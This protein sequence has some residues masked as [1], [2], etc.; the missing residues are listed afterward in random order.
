MACFHLPHTACPFQV[1]SYLLL[2]L[3][4]AP[5]LACWPL[6]TAFL[7]AVLLA[8]APPGRPVGPQI[9]VAHLRRLPS[10]RAMIPR[11]IVSCG[12][13]SPTRCWYEA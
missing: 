11:A 6:A 8:T 3:L 13:N 7:A 1:P 2:P 9:S 10:S 4:L 5:P 12:R